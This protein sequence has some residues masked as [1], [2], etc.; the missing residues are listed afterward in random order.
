M[1]K[2]CLFIFILALLTRIP[3]AIKQAPDAVSGPEAIRVAVSLAKSFCYCDALGDG[4]GSTAHVLPLNVIIQ[5][6]ALKIFGFEKAGA[7]AIKV[8]SC[9]QVACGL[10]LIPIIC[11]YIFGDKAIGAVAGILGAA[12]PANWWAQTM[13]HFEPTLAFLM[14]SCTLTLAGYFHAQRRIPTAKESVYIGLVTGLTVLTTT[15]II[16]ILA[17][18]FIYG[19]FLFK[20]SYRAY[21]KFSSITALVVVLMMS[22]WVIRNYMAFGSVIPLRSNLGLELQVSNNDISSRQDATYYDYMR[23][24]HPFT[25][26]DELQKFRDMGEISY[27]KE[28]MTLAKNWILEN[29]GSFLR[30][31]PER[32]IRF[33]FPDLQ[34]PSRA[35]EYVHNF[36]TIS[37]ALALIVIFYQKHNFR[38]VFLIYLVGFESTYLVIQANA[39]YRFPIEQ[40]VLILCGYLYVNLFRL[41]QQKL[42]D[43]TYAT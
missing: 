1:R 34:M 27:N 37:A 9:L 43:S 17:F 40:I 6:A 22:P 29:P 38:W 41:L 8:L 20:N 3:F 42:K 32:F 26:K 30:M 2:I 7:I 12:F 18:L 28:K 11:F 14:I 33:W 35:F 24:Y 39:R 15:S 19:L 23:V 10:A 36:I 16:P 13:G 25:N 21:M 31:M 4:T 5:A